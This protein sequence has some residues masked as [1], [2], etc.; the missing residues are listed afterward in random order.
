MRGL[1]R[2]ETGGAAF[3]RFPREWLSAHAA[4]MAA[5]WLMWLVG[6]PWNQAVLA[7]VPISPRWLYPL[8]GLRATSQ[9]PLSTTIATSPVNRSS[10]LRDIIAVVD[11]EADGPV[12][13]SR[14]C[15]EAAV[16]SPSRTVRGWGATG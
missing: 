14:C 1:P 5:P 9:P 16:F 15:C 10:R 6:S 8:W 4:D 3:F 7:W 12:A 13:G 11:L 2:Q